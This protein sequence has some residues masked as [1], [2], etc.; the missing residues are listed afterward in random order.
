MIGLIID[1]ETVIKFSVTPKSSLV[2]EG[3]PCVYFLL[4][5]EEL[6]YIGKTTSLKRRLHAHKDKEFDSV[7]WVD[8]IE[9]DLH[10]VERLNIE[11]HK[12]SLNKQVLDADAYKEGAH[13]MNKQQLNTM[14]TR[15]NL[16]R[17]TTSACELVLMTG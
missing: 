13:K 7:S 16:K 17:L 3:I 14:A 6:V 10:K 8:C 9:A 5:C 1:A 15:L 11:H 4:L 12:P 2:S